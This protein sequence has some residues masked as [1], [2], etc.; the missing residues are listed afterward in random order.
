MLSIYKERSVEQLLLNNIERLYRPLSKFLLCESVS[1]VKNIF[2]PKSSRIL[3]VL[4]VNF[5]RD[6]DERELA[7][8]GEAYLR[9]YILP[10]YTVFY[11]VGNF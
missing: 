6:W 4:L 8:K 5:G 11:P 10:Q 3:R 1:G 7:E 9:E 2:A